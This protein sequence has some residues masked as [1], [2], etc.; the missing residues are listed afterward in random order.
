M[1]GRSPPFDERSIGARGHN[2]PPNLYPGNPQ[3]ALP[4]QPHFIPQPYMPPQQEV[5]PLFGALVPPNPILAPNNPIAAGPAG[6]PPL[7]HFPLAPQPQQYAPYPPPSPLPIAHGGPYNGHHPYVGH[8]Q[9]PGAGSA[10]APP[11]LAP[12]GYSA[13]ALPPPPPYVPPGF[14]LAAQAFASVAGSLVG[15]LRICGLARTIFELGNLSVPY[16]VLLEIYFCADADKDGAITF[17][18]FAPLVPHLV[19]LAAFHHT[20]TRKGVGALLPEDMREALRLAGLDVHPVHMHDLF[21]RADANC[22]GFVDWR[23]FWGVFPQVQGRM[24]MTPDSIVQ[25]FRERLGAVG[26]GR[27]DRLEEKAVRQAFNDADER[28]IGQLDVM[29]FARALTFLGFRTGGY[30]M[31]AKFFDADRNGDQMIS[32]EEFRHALLENPQ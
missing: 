1:L 13:P 26:G 29:G 8:H 24:R 3:G 18:E 21:R 12:S 16:D 11:P 30:C 27:P 22:D 14:Q 20:A 23:E 25:K 2:L 15:T 6:Q 4:P 19:A 10:V 31:I 28:A 9:A 32:Y 17:D 5:Q 7:P